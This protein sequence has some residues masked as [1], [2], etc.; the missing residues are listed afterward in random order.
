MTPHRHPQLLR[1]AK[2][3]LWQVFVCHGCQVC[4]MLDPFSDE[5]DESYPHLLSA[6]AVVEIS[7]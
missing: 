6:E 3:E 4:W 5:I 7:T 2:G 1:N